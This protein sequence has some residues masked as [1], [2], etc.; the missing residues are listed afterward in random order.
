MGRA[1]GRVHTWGVYIY[2]RTYVCVEAQLPRG[3]IFYYI[4]VIPHPLSP[5]GGG[6]GKG[7]ADPFERE[8]VLRGGGVTCL[9]RSQKS[10]PEISNA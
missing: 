7:R 9:R 5:W 4:L 3:G 6:G 1:G 2:V 8:P 10:N